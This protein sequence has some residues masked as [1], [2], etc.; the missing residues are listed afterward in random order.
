MAFMTFYDKIFCSIFSQK[1][2]D[3]KKKIKQ[4]I[5]HWWKSDVPNDLDDFT[6]ASQQVSTTKMVQPNLSSLP[7]IQTV[8]PSL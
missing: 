5:I 6:N 7:K 8:D 1:H 2:Q 4:S 3:L